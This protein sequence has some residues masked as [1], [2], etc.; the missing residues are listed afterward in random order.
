MAYRSRRYLFVSVVGGFGWASA[1]LRVFHSAQV[2]A[3]EATPSKGER[4]S[5]NCSRNSPSSTSA[6]ALLSAAPRHSRPPGSGSRQTSPAG[7]PGSAPRPRCLTRLQGQE[8]RRPRSVSSAP[9]KSEGPAAA[10]M[11]RSPHRRSICSGGRGCCTPASA[12]ARL[13]PR[14]L[15]CAVDGVAPARDN[16]LWPLP[17]LHHKR[18]LQLPLVVLRGPGRWCL[19]RCLANA[20]Q[21]R[22]AAVPLRTQFTGC[23]QLASLLSPAAA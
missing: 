21:G 14:Q 9:K 22:H 15:V 16:T 8:W 13:T 23:M 5:W 10:H 7:P 6:T 4:R 18:G 3:G 20:V 2:G 19:Q 12:A 1:R 11:P 17:A